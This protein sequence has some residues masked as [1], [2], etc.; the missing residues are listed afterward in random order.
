MTKEKLTKSEWLETNGFSEDGKTIIVLGNSYSIKDK[1]KELGFKYSPLLR[2]H[3]GNWTEEKLKGISY[4]VFQFDDFFSWSEE[5]GVAFLLKGAREKI[6]QI[7]NPIR[8][9]KSEYRG[10][11]G[12]TLTLPCCTVVNVNGYNGVY[13]YTWVYTFR[14]L[15][16]NEYTWFTTVNKCLAVGT[17]CMVIG[18]VKM[19][20]EYK[21]VKTTVL[22]RCSITIHE[23]DESYEI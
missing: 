15:K 23:L 22:T 3:C 13:G 8:E 12:D 1:L 19:H 20:Q 14:D 17:Y 2:W 18:K 7:F 5:E 16:D 6:E 4:A 21:G 10:E 11:I 9:S